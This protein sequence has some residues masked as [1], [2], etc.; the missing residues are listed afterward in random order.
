MSP[1]R[2]TSVPNAADQENMNSI[3]PPV[4]D[5]SSAKQL[6]APTRPLSLAPARPLLTASRLV[7]STG[8][9]RR[10]AAILLALMIVSIVA[11]C[12]LPWQQS[13]AGTGRV[14]AYK[15][16][17][18][19]QEILAPVKG[20]VYSVPDALV[21]GAFVKAGDLLLEI[22]PAAADLSGQLIGQLANLQAKKDS[23]RIK[24]EAYGQNVTAYIAAREA[25]IEGANQN[26]QA[27]KS[28]L[29]AK[30]ELLAGYDAKLKQ[31]EANF[32]RQSSLNRQQ[33]TADKEL[34]YRRVDRDFA[35][36]EYESVL[37]E[38]EQ[39]KAELKGKEAELEQKQNEAQAK[40]DSAK[41]DQQAALG[42]MATI[43][44]EMRDLQIKQSELDR[45]EIRAP[46]DGYIQRLPVFAGGQTVKEGDY[47]LTFVPRTDEHAVELL[48]RGNDMPL[49]QPGDHVRL[50][51]EGWPALQFSG[52]PAVAVGTFGGEVALA[53]PSDD[54]TGKFR[55]MIR[56]APGEQWP[57]EKY[58]RQGVRSN[59]WIMLREVSLA[60]E[61]W[62]QLN[63]FPP[64]LK[65]DPK[66]QDGKDASK[67]PKLPK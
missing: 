33:I 7:E 45:L 15:P 2:V 6:P 25:A 55:V 40:V 41:A 28:K 14:V 59:G 1:H 3:N 39:A 54:G 24:A 46:L 66:K 11:L 43:D 48:I 63:G 36:A 29:Q 9:A 5:R 35:K 19:Q 37:R 60:Y 49:V 58:L 47:L 23:S 50:Q 26:I 42:E 62:R 27:A 12:W 21:E 32:Q 65:E 34:E 20:I 61:I 18:R 4:G 64:V 53:D 22:K 52:W 56:P 30:E 17:E 51:F 67:R 16:G 38:I 13:A 57:D 44:K 8:R 31:A 10:L